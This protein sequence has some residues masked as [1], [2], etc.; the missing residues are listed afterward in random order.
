MNKE[1]EI[2]NRKLDM[3]F[4]EIIWLRKDMEQTK[5]EQEMRVL[6][7]ELKY[8][9]SRLDDRKMSLMFRCENYDATRNA[10]RNI[11]RDYRS[12]KEPTETM[13]VL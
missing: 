2:L 3:I 8:N 1:F 5:N 13:E 10:F 9:Q 12:S 11:D 4:D 7:N 6:E